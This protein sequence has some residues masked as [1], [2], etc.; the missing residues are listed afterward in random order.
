MEHNA[1]K[2]HMK[3]PACGNGLWEHLSLMTRL[4]LHPQLN[5]YSFGET[6]K[7]AKSLR[8][9]AGSTRNEVEMMCLFVPYSATVPGPSPTT[10][11]L[12]R[13]NRSHCCCVAWAQKSCPDAVCV[14]VG[15]CAGDKNR[16]KRTSWAKYI[17]V[18]SIQYQ[19][20]THESTTWTTGF[21]KYKVNYFSLTLRLQ[22]AAS[23]GIPNL[24]TCSFCGYGISW[25]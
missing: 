3:T 21:I 14:Y 8:M 4:S 9:L 15:L 24:S 7:G 20:K 5:S 6:C 23:R 18:D 17:N 19:R 25:Q 10:I 22:P 2:R 16:F 11:I 1:A 12:N 13:T